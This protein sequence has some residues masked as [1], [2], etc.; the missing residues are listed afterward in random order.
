MKQAQRYFLLKFF[1]I[2][3]GGFLIISFGP[4]E[5]G[6]VIPFTSL[7]AR[8]SG[9]ILR[10]IGEPVT[11]TG[12]R[13]ASPQFA[14]EILNGCNGVEAML[15]LVASIFSFPASLA[16]RLGGVLAGSVAIQLLNLVRIVSL[17]LLGAYHRNIFDLF[18]SAVWQVIIILASLGIFLFWSLKFAKRADMA[19]SA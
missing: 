8:M 1:G 11:I 17:F 12:T 13:I 4:V 15:I 2:L 7:L 6:V 16:A 10:V 14:V 3:I 5:R 19:T 18:H 9:A